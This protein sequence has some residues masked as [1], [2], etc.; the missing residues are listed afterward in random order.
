MGQCVDTR[1]DARSCGG[2]GVSCGAN[3]RCVGSRCTCEDGFQSC[4]GEPGCESRTASDAM[5][6]GTCD[7]A[8]PPAQ[9]TCA[10][11]RCT[12]CTTASD[13]MDD[14]LDCTSPPTCESGRCVHALAPDRCL[15]DGQCRR[16]D[17]RDPL[18]DCRACDPRRSV[19]AWSVRLGQA[20][21]DGN[22]CTSSDL[23]SSLATCDG[24]ALSC[25]DGLTCTFD[26]CDALRGVCV[27]S[28]IS[29]TCLIEGECRAAGA[30]NPANPCQ[31][32]DPIRVRDDWSPASGSCDDGLFCTMGDTCTTTVAGPTCMGIARD[33]NDGQMC[34]TD[35]CDEPRRM[36]VHQPA[37]GSCYFDANEDGHAECVAAGTRRPMFS[38]N[39]CDPAVDPTGWTELGQGAAC[40]DGLGVCC[41]GTCQA[42]TSAPCTCTGCPAGRTCCEG[43][44]MCCLVSCALCAMM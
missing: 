12:A 9:P 13:C 42:A 3:E 33:C 32:C 34:T 1:D 27:Y 26:A 10:A 21:D 16:A 36:C 41:D 6:C 37:A 24:V 35:R 28:P 40:D 31:V 11:G 29:S 18:S 15:I 20:C 22:G 7:V 8:C 2:C 38:C 14:G 19:S 5:H 39:V 43:I 30:T 4:D 23:C 44:T 17:E 25:D